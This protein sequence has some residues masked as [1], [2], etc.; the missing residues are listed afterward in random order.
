MPEREH[1]FTI[2][3][4]KARSGSS[5]SVP[6]SAAASTSRS[7]PGGHIRL[8]GPDP[9]GQFATVAHDGAPERRQCPVLLRE[10]D[11]VDDSAF[12]QMQPR[13]RTAGEHLDVEQ[14]ELA[15]PER[16]RPARSPC[17][18]SRRDSAEGS[19]IAVRTS[20]LARVAWPTAG[21][22]QAS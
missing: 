18:L 2:S 13:S 9:F 4:A 15:G 11:L 8:T 21:V 17:A 19:T 22:R 7:M 5:V 20:P 6:S 1:R 16:P 3:A 10:P 14:T 12:E